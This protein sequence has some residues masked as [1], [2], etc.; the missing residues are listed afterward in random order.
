M[1]ITISPNSV[2]YDE[3][4]EILE[5]RFPDC[6]FNMRGKQFLVAKKSS[7]VGANI[8]LRKNKIMV[9]GNFPTIGGTLVFVLSLFLLGFLIPLIIYFAAFHSK[10]KALEKEIGAFLQENYA[11]NDI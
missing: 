9:A 6:S 7:T 4:K 1:K 3:L 8:V 2:S 11:L 10:M 5:A